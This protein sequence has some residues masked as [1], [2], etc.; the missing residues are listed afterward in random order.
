L[1]QTVDGIKIEN[2][3]DVTNEGSPTVMEMSEVNVPST[4]SVPE[5]EPQVSCFWI[6][7]ATCGMM[8]SFLSMLKL[9]T[10]LLAAVNVWV[11]VLK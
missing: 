2:D 7:F 11:D 6:V 8:I 1:Q 10:C 4:F 5:G 9:K 3:G